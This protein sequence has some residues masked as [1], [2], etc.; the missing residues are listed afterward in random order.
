MDYIKKTSMDVTSVISENK[1]V[2]KRFF[3]F[4]L[5]VILVSH[6]LFYTVKKKKTETF[7][8]F[9]GLCKTSLCII[10]TIL[11]SVYVLKNKK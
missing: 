6:K 2:C 8:L 1:T 4:F 5:K 11:K 3:F 10:N 7:Q 9:V